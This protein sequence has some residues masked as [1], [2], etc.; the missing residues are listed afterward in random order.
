MINVGSVLKLDDNK[1]YM[2][3]NKMNLHNINYVYLIT[4]KKPIEM[5][6][7]TIVE[8]DGDIRLEEIKDND[9]LDYV[10][11]QFVLNSEDESEID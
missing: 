5:L 11:S 4:M 1:E 3:I 7:A 8:Q 10:L 6:V 9:E 2:V